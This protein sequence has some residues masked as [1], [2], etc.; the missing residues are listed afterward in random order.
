MMQHWT[1]K[2]LWL[3]YLGLAIV[4]MV[5]KDREVLFLAQTELAVQK[6]A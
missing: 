1:M 6:C 5:K 3:V 2:N 4:S